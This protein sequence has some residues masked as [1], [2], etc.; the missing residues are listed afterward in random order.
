ML[1]VD[2]LPI[3]FFL[4]K[5]VIIKNNSL[6]FIYL[7]LSFISQI[8][9]FLI[10]KNGLTTTNILFLYN[11]ISNIILIVFF[12]KNFELSKL[13]SFLILFIYV[14]LSIHFCLIN[15]SLNYFII[16]SNLILILIYLF[17][18]SS[19]YY[20]SDTAINSLKLSFSLSIILYNSTGIILFV[21][22]PF[23]DKTSQYIWVFH[24]I[25]EM[26]SKLIITYS[27][28]KLPSKSIS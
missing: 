10:A 16:A 11:F 17:Y 18:L 9:T 7:S 28:W 22:L 23:L 13:Y 25:I 12:I 4:L 26:I 14:V 27:I 3:V 6:V 19:F 2:F 24:N 5:P 21:I 8:A 15:S 20:Y 1:W